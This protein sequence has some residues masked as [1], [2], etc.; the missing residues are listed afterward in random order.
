MYKATIVVPTY[1]RSGFLK[2]TVRSLCAQCLCDP[3]EIVVVDNSPEEELREY[4]TSLST[5]EG[6]EVRYVAESRTGLHYARHSGVRVAQG[7]IVV[8]VDDDVL[9]PKGWLEA[10]LAP[11]RDP[12]VAVVGGK[13]MPKWETEPPAWISSFVGGWF[14]ILDLG[15]IRVDLCKDEYVYGCNMAVRRE[16]IFEVG[17]FNPDGYGDRRLIWNRGDGECGL[18]DKI[19]FHGYKVV[20]EPH[21]WLYHRLPASR[22]TEQ[23]LYQRAFTDG[24]SFSYASFR[25]HPT[26]WLGLLPRIAGDAL[27]WF[28]WWI[29]ASVPK[30]SYKWKVRKRMVAQEYWARTQHEIRLM[31]SSSLRTHVC[32][33]SYLDE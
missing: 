3:F 13:T 23:Y 5:N 29:R 12:K 22:A 14:S 31:C 30:G 7:E 6:P 20:Y 19:R 26:N 8:F 15:D 11:Y 16:V 32:R 18:I 17:G 4:M 1:R 24:I 10:M 21:A 27:R 9:C 28:Y 2:D 33:D 25:L